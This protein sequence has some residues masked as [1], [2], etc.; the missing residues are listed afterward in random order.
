MGFAA[1]VLAILGTAQQ[2]NAKNPKTFKRI[3]HIY[4]F[5]N[6]DIETETVCEIITTNLDIARPTKKAASRK[7]AAS[8]LFENQFLNLRSYS[9]T[10]GSTS[11]D[12]TPC[13]KTPPA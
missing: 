10:S 7:D 9:V 12:D 1:V 5:E 11:S 3:S 6:T 13:V 2:A 8:S 4:A